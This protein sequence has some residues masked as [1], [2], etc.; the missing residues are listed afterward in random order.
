M[1]SFPIFFIFKFYNQNCSTYKSLQRIFFF[2]FIFFICLA[3]SEEVGA[4]WFLFFLFYFTSSFFYKK[5][6]TAK[7]FEFLYYQPPDCRFSW[8]EGIRYNSKYSLAWDLYLNNIHLLCFHIIKFFFSLSYLF[9]LILD[10]RFIFIFFFGIER[11][12]IKKRINIL[13]E[14]YLPF[15]VRK[16]WKCCFVIW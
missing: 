13:V 16:C 2:F 3:S 8:N 6:K 11:I 15:W 9:V 10:F 5:R 12:F 7:S 4:R 14:K 1:S